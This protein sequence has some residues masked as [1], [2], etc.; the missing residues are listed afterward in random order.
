MERIKLMTNAYGIL[1]H[2]NPDRSM[3]YLGTIINYNQ[4]HS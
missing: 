1:R 2:L 4:R 3:T